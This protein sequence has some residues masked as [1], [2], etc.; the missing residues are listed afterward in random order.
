MAR[1]KKIKDSLAGIT[2]FA[3]H[4]WPYIK[5][6]KWLIGVALTGLFAQ[7]ALRLL[8][9]WPLKYIID[10]LVYPGEAG[11]DQQLEMLSSFDAATYFAILAI[12][13]VV[14]TA[15][16]SLMTYMATISTALAGNHVLTK[17][18]GLLFKHLQALS[19]SFHH[20][21][22]S[23]DLVVR[24]I[25]DIGLV[26]EVAITAIIPL[27]G[28]SLIFIG[29]VGVM[30]WL[31]W[32]LALIALSTLPLLW[33]TTIKRGKRIQAVARKNRKR[34]G[35]MA[36]T[37][38][39][40]INSIKTVQALALEETFADTF[41]SANA[42]SLKEGVKTKKLTAGLERSVD[43]LIAI[44]TA[45]VLWFGALQVLKGTLTP[46]GLLVFIY[47]LRRVFRPV[48]DFAK[49]TA[50]LAKASAAGERVLDLLERE[51]DVKDLPE[52]KV[53]P[54]LS[55]DICFKSVSFS[56]NSDNV[57]ALHD[58]NLEIKSGEKLTIVGPSGSG[59][60]TLT[61][62]LMRLYD[63]QQGDVT[64]GGVDVRDY[65]LESLRP[66]ISIVLQE[67]ILFATSIGGNI[68]VGLN[69]VDPE[70]IIRASKLANIHDFIMTLPEA[71]DTQVGERG[72]TLSAGQRQRISI[73]RAAVRK[74]PILILD[75][76]TTGLDPATEKSVN[77]ALDRL[78]KDRTTI[79]ITHRPDTA[80][81]SDHI[82]FI[83]NG[84][85]IEHG[86]HDALLQKNDEYVR[87]FSLDD[88]AERK[89]QNVSGG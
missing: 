58:I 32:Q 41:G 12:A 67:T 14:I 15:L 87:L 31:N 70:E 71:Y 9:P 81:D 78:A 72:V 28:N 38:S 42:K 79:V 60:S 68:T 36:A 83:H 21:E 53:A 24:V 80:A 57:T 45:M 30:L 50:R 64:I 77:E 22:R 27:A 84:R 29:I 56:Y 34:E 11:K 8:E 2:R 43:I 69:D 55:G 18:R 5:E 6:Q 65:T 17:I 20:K 37:A 16:R 26:K 62:L 74:T 3:R 35:A 40:S 63:P 47:Y 1:P 49:Y 86:S 85:I 88:A 66:Q 73:A 25:S 54:R 75:E 23:G 13:L 59:K 51:L 82:I 76:P 61:G 46:G 89:E 33:L 44:S 19:L 39:E 52:A 7:T 10:K 48:R 4:F